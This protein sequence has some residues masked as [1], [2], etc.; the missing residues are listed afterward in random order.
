MW[1]VNAITREGPLGV[2]G[3]PI[4]QCVAVEGEARRKMR[5]RNKN[6]GMVALVLAIVGT[7]SVSADTVAL[8]PAKDNTLYQNP[9]GARSN[10][11]GPFMFA[12]R[13]SQPTNSI[14]RGALAFDIA[15]SIPP[16]A[17]IISAS[18]TLTTKSN[19]SGSTNIALHRAISDW[20][21]GT[22]DAGTPGG[23]GAPSTTG[24]ATWIHTV[25]D[26][27]FWTT[28]GGDFQSASSADAPVIGG[29]PVTW[30]ST[31]NLV[32]DVQAWLDSPSTNFGWL[33]IGDETAGGTATRYATRENSLANERPQLSV[34]FVSGPA[35]IPT[36]SQWGLV[37]MLALLLTLGKIVFSA[38]QE[39]C[40]HV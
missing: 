18:L 22:S 11:A 13:N 29:G 17:T 3:V 24:D 37:I 19:S 26:A 14:R 25:F 9:M 32:A 33:L 35:G 23:G 2:S 30:T 15:G 5:T 34:E 20:G 6:C 8:L 4:K 21:E 7:S 27:T 40:T 1:R 39:R 16:G 31:A 10:G 36:V 38:P 12:G 28:P